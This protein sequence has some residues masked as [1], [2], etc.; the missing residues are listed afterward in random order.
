M[1]DWDHDG[2]P[3]LVVNSIWGEVLWYRNVGS[4]R[5]PVLAEA[6]PIEVRWPGTP[7]KPAGQA[8]VHN[9]TGE[10]FD[11]VMA[12][13]DQELEAEPKETETADV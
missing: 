5:H 6:S 7:P 2:R 4:R 10:T 9:E 1:A 8:A 3:D 11:Q 13:R 12:A